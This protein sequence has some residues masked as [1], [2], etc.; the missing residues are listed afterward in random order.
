MGRRSLWMGDLYVSPNARRTGAARALLLALAARAQVLGCTY[1]TSE[2]WRR[3]EVARAFYAGLGAH[4]EDE[5]APMSLPVETLVTR[6]RGG[7]R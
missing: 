7:L 4:A 5:V 3:T 2:L 6:L 1:I